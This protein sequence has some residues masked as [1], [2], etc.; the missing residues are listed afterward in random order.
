M[1]NLIG[2]YLGSYKI[3]SLLGQ[4]GMATVYKAYQAN[5]DRHVAIKVLPIHYAADP[6]FKKRFSQEA[7]TIAKLEHPHILPVHDFGEADGYLYIVMRIV[8]TGS[9]ADLLKQQPLLPPA[10]I[11]QLVTQIAD[12][13]DYAHTHGVIHRDIKPGNVLLDERGNCLLTDFGIAK[14]AESS[15]FFTNTGGILGTPAYMSPEQALGQKLDGRS[16]IYA[17][18]VILYQMATKTLP[19]KADTPMALAFKHVNE[20]L[21]PPR[22]VNSSIPSQVEQVII[23]SLSK[24]P[25][26]RFATARDLAQALWSAM[27][28]NASASYPPST[29]LLPTKIIPTT[30]TSIVAGAILGGFIFFILLLSYLV[31]VSQNSLV[32]P[33]VA[34]A[35]ASPLATFT[36]TPTITP[37]P[38]TTTGSATLSH[39]AAIYEGPGNTYALVS[40][41]NGGAKVEV[42]GRNEKGTWVQ[43][44]HTNGPDGHAWIDVDDIELPLNVNDLTLV[45]MNIATVT[46][47]ETP[48]PSPTSTNTPLPTPTATSSP[49]PLP[50]A[51]Q[52]SQPTATSTSLP[53]SGG[54]TVTTGC[55]S[56]YTF[57]AGDTLGTVAAKYTGVDY[58]AIFEATNA[59]AAKDKSYATIADMNVINVG[60]KLCIPAAGTVAN[61]TS[62]KTSGMDIPM[63]KSAVSFE[64]LSPADAVIDVISS[65]PIDSQ[66]VIPNSKKLFVL[67]PGSY[68][69]NASSPGGA[70]STSGEFT[71]KADQWAE[72]VIFGNT[73]NVVIHDTTT[74]MEAAPAMTKTMEAVPV[75][76]TAV[77]LAPTAG[78]ARVY[79][80][81]KFRGEYNIDFGDGGGSI[82]VPIG[83]DNFYREF[84]PGSYKPGLSL[85]GGGAANV[86]L[87]LAADQ[88]WVILVDEQAQVRVGQIYP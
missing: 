71:L 68:K 66:R 43:I 47:T 46:P 9:L 18:G 37:T 28:G 16:D 59:A 83:N 25:A 85:P 35:I 12:A 20:P 15:T 86:D 8:E 2:K 80:Q 10:Q 38:T 72:V 49:T 39:A 76:T 7:R 41:L 73:N 69:F 52:V 44:I 64:N 40:N 82:K 75:T 58:K 33:T 22:T 67:E 63:G 24:Q 31:S 5:M 65:P 81:N 60:E 30:K 79:L 13:L 42:M 62:T 57:A 88:S 48:T 70:Y 14:I 87:N 55:V 54:K 21:P 53:S 17:L 61:S 29:V 3:I 4:G 45:T 1:E 6:N 26:D 78:K 27:D 50:T 19:F 34:V 11:R 51:T 56:D 74:T 32:T 23:K 84:A 77:S 36:P